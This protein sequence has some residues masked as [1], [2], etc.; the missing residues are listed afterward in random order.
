MSW[1][2]PLAL[3]RESLPPLLPRRFVPRF[4]LVISLPPTV[5]LVGAPCNHERSVPFYRNCSTS[6]WRGSL[7][8]VPFVHDS[9][10]LSV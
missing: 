4:A 10:L 2:Y 5:R 6:P 7:R 9:T 8:V 1:L 3:D